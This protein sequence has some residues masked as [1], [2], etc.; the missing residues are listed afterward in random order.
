MCIYLN[1]KK[2]VFVL[3]LYKYTRKE[4]NIKRDYIRYTVQDKAIFFDLKTEKCMSASAV[5]K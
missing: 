5:A 2:A 4:A 1:K 3:F